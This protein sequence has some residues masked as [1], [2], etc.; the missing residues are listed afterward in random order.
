MTVLLTH[1]RGMSLV[2]HLLFA[3]IFDISIQIPDLMMSCSICVGGGQ[4]LE[5][6]RKKVA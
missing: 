5:N 4:F 1:L 3:A 6:V 2:N